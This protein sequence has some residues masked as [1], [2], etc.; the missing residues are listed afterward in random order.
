MANGWAARSD[1]LL[2][3]VLILAS[4]A[5]AQEVR[6]SSKPYRPSPFVLRVESNLVEA[7]VVVRDHHGHAV[8]GLVRDDFRII[9]DGKEREITAFSIE[10]AAAK[11]AAMPSARPSGSQAGAELHPAKANAGARY[12]ALLFDDVSTRQR[13][14]GHARVAAERFV[15]ESMQPGDR[16]AIVTTSGTVGSPFTADRAALAGAIGKLRAHPRMSEDGVAPC[17][18]ITP[19]QAYLIVSMD[20]TALQSALDEAHAC[21]ESPGAIRSSPT[22][23]GDGSMSVFTVRAQAEQTWDQ[24]KMVS[25][26]AL[27][28]IRRVV[29]QLAMMPGSRVLLLASSGFLA[30]TME[31][32]QSRIVDQ[33]LAANVVINAL[34]AKGLFSDTPV[35][36][37]D[38]LENLTS[39]PVTTTLFEARTQ[40]SALET[41]NA[42][43]INF[44]RSTGGLFFHN[45]NDLTLGFQVLAAVPEITYRL[46]FRPGAGGDG[47]YH[48]LQVKLAKTGA[49]LL[50]ARRGYF[51]PV[52]GTGLELSPQQ[53]LDREVSSAEARDDFPASVAVEE[54]KSEGGHP[55]LRV[56]VH[57]DL[58][59]LR[60]IE[61]AAHHLE[62]LVFVTALLDANGHIVAA[63]EGRMDLDLTQATFER[64]TK[65]GMNAR[66][67]LEAPPGT[68]QLR[69]V[70]QEAVGGKMAASN[71]N[72]HIE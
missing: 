71:R 33:A 64:L 57:V 6:V 51:A 45:S 52:R 32:Q 72:V 10:A 46:G 34:D 14:L 67:S 36:R 37:P 56:Q 60:F 23:L 25:K 50:Q 3:A 11:L 1:L 39:L 31:Y 59:R 42:P 53:K 41:A 26:G 19:Y 29:E 35:R 2:G 13:D 20:A 65:T 68:Y 7:G 12:V 63:K 48:K 22:A 58:R 55:L 18:R 15:R 66:L 30:E 69:E 9:D 5:P 8:P 43:L 28:T 70:V 61:R 40:L 16:V 44:A 62:G 21:A 47:R 54:S 24:A 38:Q 27:D 49:Y 17:P 4:Q